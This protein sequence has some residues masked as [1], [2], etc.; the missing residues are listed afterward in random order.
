MCLMSYAN[1]KGAD[2]PAYPHNLITAFVIRFLDSIISLDSIAE[3]SRLQLASVAAQACL[4]LAWSETPEDT[5]CRVVGHF[6]LIHVNILKLTDV[7][8]YDKIITI[9]SKEIL[10]WTASS[11]F[12]T[13]RLC[14]QRRFRRACASAQSHQNLRCSLI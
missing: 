5:F 3:I 9:H 12:G 7:S 11:E 6:V 4:C 10:I 8:S 14:E 2:Q 13:Y 1:N